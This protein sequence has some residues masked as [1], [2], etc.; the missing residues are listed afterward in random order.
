MTTLTDLEAT[1]I[2]LSDAGLGFSE[3]AA[4]VCRSVAS[5]KAYRSRA[6]RKLG[7]GKGHFVDH[8]E[9]PEAAQARVARELEAGA[10]CTR[11]HLSGH[12]TD[13][14]DLGSAVGF[15]V[16]RRYSPMDGA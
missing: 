6:L 4:R 5:I 14:C 10:R 15:A 13:A 3:I 16:R 11:C 9:T 12:A 8:E 7:R 1:V 2:K